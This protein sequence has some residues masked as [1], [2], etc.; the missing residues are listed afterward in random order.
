MDEIIIESEE[1]SNIVYS[2]VEI[3]EPDYSDTDT[4]TDTDDNEPPAVDPADDDFSGIDLPDIPGWN[5]DDD[6]DTDVDDDTV[7]DE[8]DHPNLDDDTDTDTD[9]NEPPAV[10]PADDDF[11]G[12]DLPDIPGWNTDDDDD[13]TDTDTDTDDD[14]DGGGETGVGEPDHPGLQSLNP[15]NTTNNNPPV[16]PSPD[17]SFDPWGDNNDPP[18]TQEPT[19]VMEG[20]SGNDTY[21]FAQGC[22]DTIIRETSGEDVILLSETRNSNNVVFYQNDNNLVI[23]YGVVYDDG[24]IIVEDYF[25]N[26]GSKIEKIQLS[27]NEYLESSEIDSIIQ[28]MNAYA[29]ENGIQISSAN[30]IANNDELMQ[31][32]TSGWQS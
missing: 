2:G 8:P 14:E 26:S 16:V 32:V 9:D 19:D 30:D 17:D 20:G 21:V 12:I 18:T 1:N 6:T 7:V 22:K 11:S 23:N 29:A 13:D 3:D 25:L 31:L 28:N 24:E 15:N 4:D 5:T 27:N 10:D